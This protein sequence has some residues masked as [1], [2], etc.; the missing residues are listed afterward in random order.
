MYAVKIGLLPWLLGAVRWRVGNEGRDSS[1]GIARMPINRLVSPTR[2][3]A[4]WLFVRSGVVGKS[5]WLLGLK[6]L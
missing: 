3:I 5:I 4:E 1:N 2:T 6:G